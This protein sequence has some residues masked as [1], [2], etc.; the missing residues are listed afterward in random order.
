MAR[1]TAVAERGRAR[2]VR[3]LG[4]LRAPPAALA[5]G[6]LEL[7]EW[8]LGRLIV[9]QLEREVHSADSRRAVGRVDEL[10]HGPAVL[11]GF[12]GHFVLRD[13]PHEVVHFLREAA[14]PK[15]IEHRVCPPA[16]IWRLLH[17]VAIADVAECRERRSA[18]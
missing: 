11:A 1:R 7:R 13:A 15:L 6:R 12:A 5:A 16:G 4:S 10:K 8:R 3:F 14:V 18:Q 2:A 9:S 17:G